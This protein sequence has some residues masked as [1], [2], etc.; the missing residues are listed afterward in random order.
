M[1][2]KLTLLLITILT[3]GVL[4]SYRC[5]VE[6]PRQF[7]REVALDDR[8]S[9]G[10]HLARVEGTVAEREL[11]DLWR[12]CVSDTAAW[13]KGCG[14]RRKRIRVIERVWGRPNETLRSQPR[15]HRSER[16]S[17]EGIDLDRSRGKSY[18]RLQLWRADT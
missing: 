17:Y 3:S 8:A 16:R 14:V 6:R 13:T 10:Q 9:D 4:E 5:V 12:D 11:E 2:K 15:T 7:H 1:L 18:S